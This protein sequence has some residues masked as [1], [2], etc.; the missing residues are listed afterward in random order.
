MSL[1]VINLGLPKTGTTTLARALRRAGLSVADHRIKAKQTDDPALQGLF[2][3]AQMYR[4]YFASGDPLRILQGFDAF[5]EIST[6]TGRRSV[7]PQ[8]DW[9]LLQAIRTHHPGVKFLASRRD[10]RDLSNAMLRWGDLATE[11][12][13]K[14]AVPGL[15]HGYGKTTRERMIWIAGHDAH[16]DR[17][18]AGDPD[19]LAYDI[20]DPDA[21]R[22][23][24][25]HIGRTLPWWGKANANPRTLQEVAR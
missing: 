9:G 15:P 16:L 2:V 7:W 23:I 4:D 3:G 22:K 8:M 13:P 20:T 17:L 1:K 12:L 11:R 19:Y 6:L 14:R 18:F 24:G 25:A 5:T 21:P 10:P